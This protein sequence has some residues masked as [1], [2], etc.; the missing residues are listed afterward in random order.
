MAN[1]LSP[2]KK[3]V[4][5]KEY[6]IIQHKIP[7]YPAI[8][9]FRGE[10]D[11]QKGDTIH[12]TK[13]NDLNAYNVGSEGSFTRQDLTDTDETLVVNNE[14]ESSFYV[15]DFDEFQNH[16]PVLRHKANP[17][18]RAIFNQ[19]D[20]DVLATYDQF[21]YNLDAGD[22][23]GSSG[24]GIT[25]SASNIVNVFTGAKMK[26]QRNNVML[27]STVSFANM[28]DDNDAYGM[29]VAVISPEMYQKLLERLDGKDT[30]LG[31]K[32]GTNGHVGR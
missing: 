25:V 20:A 16:L 8:A 31:D 7:V 11:L 2:G 29:G 13:N 1:E 26:L 12:R 6:Q 17:A 23:G 27:D 4:W 10:A 3:E 19:I 32:A 30:E 5:A 9:N 21:T 24:E 18:S 14:K 28:R 15:R 22:V